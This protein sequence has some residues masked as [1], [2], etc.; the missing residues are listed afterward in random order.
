MEAQQT[1]TTL[2]FAPPLIRQ[3]LS[4]EPHED[5]GLE[6]FDPVTSR[7]FL[8]DDAQSAVFLACNGQ[9]SHTEIAKQVFDDVDE[10]PTVEVFVDALRALGLL[11]MSGSQ[12]DLARLQSERLNLLHQPE[13]DRSLLET[14]RNAAAS[15][16]LYRERFAG[17]AVDE[18]D[19]L[20][21]LP[22][23]TKSDIRENFPGRL[24]PDDINA[25]EL[26]ERNDV[27][28]YSTSGT[29][30]D[31]LQVLYDAER[32]GYPQTFPGIRAVP[33]GWGNA[34]IALFTTPVCSGTV[35]HMGQTKF[36]DRLS[37]GGAY[38]SL[39]SSDRVMSLTRAELVEIL[40]DLERFKPSILRVD[41][42]YAVA[43]IRALQREQLPIPSVDVIWTAYEY[44]TLIHRE[45]IEEAF[46]CPVFT[47]YA[48]TDLGGGCQ[49]FRCREGHFH[50]R[51]NQ[52]LFEFLD[53]SDPVDPGSVGQITVTSTYHRFMPLIRY[54]V[55]D[56][57]R[58]VEQTCPC[59]HGDWDAFHLEGRTRDCM[60]ST[61]GEIVTTRSVDNLFEGLNWA[62]FY[63]VKQ[64]GAN[65]FEL[66][67]VR[68]PGSNDQAPQW[69]D[70][71]RELLGA[72][73]S[74]REVRE[75]REIPTEKSFKFR[76]TGS[77]V[78][79]QRQ[80]QWK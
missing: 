17:V 11:E 3:D 44:C 73:A 12:A 46:K 13:W 63:E 33:G 25:S 14:V 19:D 60:V 38:L 56:L 30:G 51:R 75:V 70:R 23:L 18:V 24:L 59:S 6:V 39:N 50:V 48:A 21:N 9:L 65:D 31:R 71:A 47:V 62:D 15:V 37:H 8:F 64:H 10:V 27:W 54:R 2:Y 34:R 36:E 4:S 45:I 40:E 20:Q 66:M 5:G 68:R 80:H 79:A 28:L 32:T 7:S 58:P 72:D 29:T 57:G 67:V 69:M 22:L 49:A 35:C 53:G 78:W 1:S 55:G 26:L 61:S 41:P 77:T 42:I 16:P 43:L 76:L 52:Y 74:F